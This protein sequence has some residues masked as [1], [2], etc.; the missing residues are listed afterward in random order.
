MN[1]MFVNYDCAPL[2]S[3]SIHKIFAL[4]KKEF[5][6]ANFSQFFPRKNKSRLLEI[7]PGE[8][9]LLRLWQE[10][11]YKKIEAIDISQTICKN[12]SK[13]HL[14]CLLVSESE[15]FLEKHKNQYD[16]IAAL[17][18]IEHLPYTRL[19]NF[20][21]TIFEALKPG[22]CFI[23]SV[24]N[25]QS[26]DALAIISM[27]VTHQTIIFSEASLT[28]LLKSI[29]FTKIKVF[30]LKIPPSAS[31]NL[32]IKTLLFICQNLVAPFYFNLVKLRRL[33][34]SGFYSRILHRGLGVAAYKE[35]NP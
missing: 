34:T 33:A 13:Q 11:G 18:V 24:P 7:G 19:E 9:D 20:V 5:I 17:D 29:G 15:K 21:K 10:L 12:L 27:D 25:S 4:D 35:D 8:G 6:K 22:G 3:F 30:G 28:Q 14:P 23:L 16:L 1:K 31:Q 2:K 32:L 26:P